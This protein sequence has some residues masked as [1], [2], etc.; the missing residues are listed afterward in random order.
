[1]V[2]RGFHAAAIMGQLRSGLRAY[3]LDGMTPSS[4]LERLSRLLRQL[5]P[6]R[7]ATLLYLVLDP[8][9]GSFTVSSAGHPPPLIAREDGDPTFIDLPGS[10]PLGAIRNARYADL[11]HAL[12]PGDALVLYTDGLVE[13]AG[14]SLDVGL[15][16]LRAAVTGGIGELERLGDSLVAALLPSGPAE[17]DAALL[18][19]RAL[20]LSESVMVRFPADIESIPLMRRMLGRWLDEAGATR[21]EAEDVALAASEACA[22]AIEHA[23][24]LAPG[25]LEVSASKSES[26]E[27]IVEVRDYGSWRAPRGQNRGRGLL[28]MEGLTD[29]VEVTQ[30]DD[31]TTV[32]LVRRLGQEAA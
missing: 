15:G 31:G 11:D 12:E 3:A 6:E 19:A 16:R 9:G 25:I 8:H 24:G 2:G 7:T 29:S 18:L 21:A 13:R 10:A 17:D 5:E 14:E 27:A 4:V 23:Y 28:L 30:G 22:N 26:G 20:P 32:L 1:V